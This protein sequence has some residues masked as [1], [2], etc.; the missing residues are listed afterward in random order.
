MRRGENA[1]FGEPRCVLLVCS[2][3]GHLAQLLAL[4]P[5]WQARERSWVTFETPDASSQLEGE[6]VDFAHFPTTR[7]V[8][9]LLRNCAV[10]AKVLRRRRPDVIVSTGAGVA[11]PFFVLAKL[12][13]IQTI[14]VEVYD[15]VTS[16]TV[17]GCVCRP[18]S[19]VFC[20]QWPEQQSLYPGS[21]VIGSLL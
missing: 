2:S 8:P 12:L 3:G 7:N 1:A 4:R 16:R 18:L 15:R 20:V 9:N 21:A 13:G 10:A 11:I 19:S 14:Y 6:S 5:W 17:T